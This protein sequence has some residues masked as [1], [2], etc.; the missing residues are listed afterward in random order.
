MFPLC[1]GKNVHL[2]N[3]EVKK[4]LWIPSHPM[5]PNR[6]FVYR[7]DASGIRTLEEISPSVTVALIRRNYS[8]DTTCRVTVSIGRTILGYLFLPKYKEGFRRLHCGWLWPSVT[9]K[10]EDGTK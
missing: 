3:L 10:P 5:P 9:H 8:F 2:I 6:L 4:V 1:K 7:E